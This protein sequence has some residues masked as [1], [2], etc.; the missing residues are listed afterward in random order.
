M[1]KKILAFVFAAAL[2]M[3][4]AVPL[5]AGAGTV[6]AQV[7]AISQAGCGENQAGG[8]TGATQ[9]SPNTPGGPGIGPIPVDAGGNLIAGEGGNLD[10]TL[11]MG[12]AAT[13]DAPGD[14]QQNP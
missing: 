12:L 8:N 3:A 1:H 11:E 5:F 13:C 14:V 10:G 7:H 9:S 4:L 6:S 2:L